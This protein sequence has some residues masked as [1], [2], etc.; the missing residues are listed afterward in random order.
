MQISTSQ[1]RPVLYGAL[2]QRVCRCSELLIGHQAERLNC[3][4][5]VAAYCYVRV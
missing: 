5:D 2:C 4:C 1:G 3:D